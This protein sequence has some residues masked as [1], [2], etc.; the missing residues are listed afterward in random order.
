MGVLSQTLARLVSSNTPDAAQKLNQAEQYGKQAIAIA[1]TLKKPDGMTDQMFATVENESLAMAY[2]GLGL[3]SVRRG[4]YADAIPQLANKPSNWIP[5]KTLPICTCWALRTRIPRILP[6]L[7]P[8]FPNVLKPLGAFR[9]PAR[10]T[11][12]RQRSAPRPSPLLLTDSPGRWLRFFSRTSHAATPAVMPTLTYRCN[13]N[14]CLC[15]P[16]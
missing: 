16:D 2:S 9:R 4:K 12:R 14:P 5:K 1:P 3:V 11:Q 8:P 15:L 6:K 10:P 13:S 7:R